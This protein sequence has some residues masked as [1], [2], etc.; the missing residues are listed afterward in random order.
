MLKKDKASKLSGDKPDPSSIE[1]EIGEKV[2]FLL[3]TFRKP[4]GETYN[5]R[6]VEEGTHGEINYSWL[7]KLANGHVNNPGIMAL[8]SLTTFFGITPDFWFKDL[9][10]WVADQTSVTDNELAGNGDE[11]ERLALYAKGLNAEDLGIVINL[12]EAFKKRNK[13]Q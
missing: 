11:L 8:K 1:S 12:V 4:N 2:R 6:E 5:Y 10:E 13:K 9:K 3:A 7:W